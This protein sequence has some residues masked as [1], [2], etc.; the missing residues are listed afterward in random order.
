[1]MHF[2]FTGTVPTANI[3]EYIFSRSELWTG[4]DWE[5]SYC[6]LFHDTA[7]DFVRKD[8]GNL[9]E[10]PQCTVPGQSSNQAPPGQLH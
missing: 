1:M 3:R 2:T 4:S 5:G 9:K 7:S 6:S 10:T 8:L